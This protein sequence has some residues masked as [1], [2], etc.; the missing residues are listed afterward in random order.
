MTD[1]PLPLTTQPR[2]EH[3]DSFHA[4][5]L[6]GEFTADGTQGGPIGALWQTFVPRMGE[7]IKPVD[8]TTYGIC[9]PPA[10]GQPDRFTYMAAMAVTDLDQIPAGMT[11]ITMPAADYLVFDYHGG[12][13]PELPKAMAWIFGQ[14]LPEHGLQSTGPDFERYGPEFDP[15]SG[16]GTF[17]IWVPVA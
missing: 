17:G 4:V 2:R 9:C 7:I 14:Y 13:G 10:D 12:L 15:A 16:T 5:G 6:A 11:G 1:T 8:D 3:L